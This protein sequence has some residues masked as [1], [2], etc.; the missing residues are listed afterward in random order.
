V[1]HGATLDLVPTT[2]PRHSITETPPVQEALNALRAAQG[3]DRID[4]SELT[5]LGAQEKLRRLERDSDAA[6]AAR[7]R[8]AEM[9]R[10]GEIPVDIEA[11]DEVKR[12]GLVANFD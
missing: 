4:F 9:I 2:R 11:A 1:Q 6:R 10:T 3:S 5:V 8:L 12:L 7:E